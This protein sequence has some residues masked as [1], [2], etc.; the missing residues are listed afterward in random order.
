VYQIRLRLA[1][2]SFTSKLIFFLKQFYELVYSEAEL[3]RKTVWQN[4]FTN[5][6][7]HECE[8]EMR[9]RAGISYFFQLH[10]NSFLCEKRRKIALWVKLF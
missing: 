2:L 9:K 7:M 5:S 4:S 1:Q 8:R 10:H 6:F 3:F